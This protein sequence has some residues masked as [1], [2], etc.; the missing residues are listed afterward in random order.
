[1][2]E[3]APAISIRPASSTADFQHAFALLHDYAH[4]ITTATGLDPFVEQPSFASE[5]DDLMTTYRESG[6]TLLIAFDG[7]V[8]VATVAIVVH[9]DRRA[10]LKRM[11]VRPSTRGRGIAAQMLSAAIDEAAR[12]GCDSIWLESLSGVMDRAISLY[13][14]FGFRP[15]TN[16]MLTGVDG[17]VA[18]E[19]PLAA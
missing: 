1:M 12:H 9:A 15:T 3:L 6:A 11:Y 8:P 2:S 17:M 5:I 18:L 16:V 14:S 10:E 13:E 7:V 4:W 19:L